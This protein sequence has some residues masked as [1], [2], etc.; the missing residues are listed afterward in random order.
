MRKTSAELGPMM[1]PRV[2]VRSESK[3]VINS[4]LE[5]GGVSRKRQKV[6]SLGNELR[7]G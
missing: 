5:I 2:G 7:N 6:N 3:I 4:Y 1:T